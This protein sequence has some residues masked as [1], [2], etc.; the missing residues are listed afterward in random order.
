MAIVN[1]INAPRRD[2][3]GGTAYD[4]QDIFQCGVAAYYDAAAG[5]CKLDTR[6]LPLYNFFCPVAGGVPA[7]CASSVGTFTPVD[8]SSMVSM[9]QVIQRSFAPSYTTIHDTNTPS[10]AQM[11]DYFNKPATLAEHLATTACVNSLYASMPTQGGTKAR[12]LYYPFTFTLY[13]LPFSWFYQCTLSGLV[14]VDAS[15][16]RNVFACPTHASR[17]TPAEYKAYTSQGD[18]FATYVTKVRGGYTAAQVAAYSASSVTRAQADWAQAVREVL[19]ETFSN[20]GADRTYAQCFN[21]QDWIEPTD[22]WA[23]VIIRSYVNPTCSDA[24]LSQGIKQYN[25]LHKTAMSPS[26]VSAFLTE[27][28]G[29][30]TPQVFQ[31]YGVNDTAVAGGHKSLMRLILDFGS[32]RLQSKGEVSALQ[33]NRVNATQTEAVQ[34]DPSMPDVTDPE[35]TLFI[36]QALNSDYLP[37]SG[38]LPGYQEYTD[39]DCPRALSTLTIGSEE[40]RYCPVFST[41][42]T[43]CAY[44]PFAWGVPSQAFALDA[45]SSSLGNLQAYFTGLYSAVR[46]RYALKTA[47]GY[48]GLRASAAELPFFTDEDAAPAT[49]FNRAFV[50]D[51]TRVRSYMME[52]N[53]NPNTPVMCTIGNQTIN[54]TQCTDPNF[55]ALQQ[56]VRQTY[57]KPGPRT[58]PPGSQLDWDTARAMLVA[59]AIYSFASTQRD[60]SRQ[61]L[62]SLFDNAT[63][64]LANN[65]AAQSRVCQFTATGG[66]A[67]ARSVTPWLTGSW[68]PFDKCD[69]TDSGV[70]TSFTE[71]VDVACQYGAPV[72]DPAVGAS[73]TQRY[74]QQMPNADACIRKQGQKTVSN[75]VYYNTGYNLC[76]QTVNEDDVCQHDQ[77]M[78]GGTDGIP[79]QD[80]ATTGNLYSLQNFTDLVWPEGADLGLFGSVLLAGGAADYGFIRVPASHIGGHHLGLII[81]PNANPSLVG[82]MR[83]ARVPLKAPGRRTQLDTWDSRDVREWVAQLNAS[84]AA[85]DAAYQASGLKAGFTRGWECPLRQRAFYTSSVPKFAPSLPSARRSKILFGDL[86]GG[87]YAHPTQSRGSAADQFG[88]YTTTNGFCFCPLSEEI[89]R[90]QCSVPLGVTNQSD[91]SLWSTIQ[92]LRGNLWLSSRTFAPRTAAND[93]KACGVQMDWPFVGGSLRDGSAI[94]ASDAAAQVWAQ[95]SDVEARRCHVLDRM[96]EFRY[97]YASEA[98]LRPSGA[99]TLASGVCHTG[100]VQRVVASSSR[101]VRT[102]KN[103]DNAHLR[104]EAAGAVPTPRPSSKTPAQAT[105]RARLFRQRCSTCSPVP[106][107]KSRGG[108]PIPAES[109]FGVPYRHSAERA[110]AADLREAVCAGQADCG[111]ILNETS[112]APGAFMAAYLTAPHT[113]FLVGDTPGTPSAG[114][115][116]VEPPDDTQLWARPWVYC[117]SKEALRTGANCTG[118]IPKHQWRANKVD[119]CHASITLALDGRQDPMAQTAVCNMDGRLSALCQAIDKARS[120]VASANCIASGD[121]ACA[122]Q[123]F[124]YSPSTWETSN[125]QFVHETVRTYY[126][127]IDRATPD[128]CPSDIDIAQLKARNAATL[129]LC[130]AVPISA[131]AQVLGG[132][133]GLVVTMTRVITI[134][135]SMG[136]HLLSTLGDSGGFGEAK[137]QAILDWQELKRVMGSAAGSVSDLFADLILFQGAVGPWLLRMGVSACNAIN[138]ASAYFKSVWCNLLIWQLPAFLGGL[139]A[140]ATW[141]DVGFQTL[142]DFMDTIFMKYLPQAFMD[143]AQRGYRGAFQ[144]DLFGNKKAAYEKRQA[145]TVAT[146]AQGVPM[147]ASERA[148]YNQRN[149][150][151]TLNNAGVSA[152]AN[153]AA[154]DAAGTAAGDAAKTT[155]TATGE[156]LRALGTIGTAASVVMDLFNIYQGYETAKKIAEAMENYPKFWTVFDFDGIYSTIDDL[157]SFIAQDVTCYASTGAAQLSCSAATLPTL[158]SSQA[159]TMAPTP[160][161]CWAEAQEV[162][163]MPCFVLDYLHFKLTCL[164]DDLLF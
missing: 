147:T 67:K 22:V 153:N 1:G 50:F 84:I 60:I 26:T 39:N 19:S 145:N 102:E 136:F 44:P 41:G 103:A 132:V 10:L 34:Y 113:L 85:D 2:T 17:I 77:G 89:Q 96:D 16:T 56:H 149:T 53:P 81:E 152:A 107:F 59:G 38:T 164:L 63:S 70:D 139:K 29:A 79:V 150:E 97:Q 9:C 83:V 45:S 112:W 21:E 93:D 73:T 54:F 128:I 31:S 104:C 148:A 80:F 40:V 131:F 105:E 71:T 37:A 28:T 114:T 143:M 116:S 144:S 12:G 138:D 115:A 142:N 23:K 47:G 101:C 62:L 69:V 15:S 162:S 121:P 154:K 66:L 87:K 129:Q 75:N 163:P 76:K 98:R 156:T 120:L 6:V 119:T 159:M 94:L 122:V 91:C 68:N 135:I 100:R 36:T 109:S 124:V 46:S 57:L 111:G 161:M 127:A 72:C 61:Y 126:N 42:P 141:C 11:F 3:S 130:P 140:L 55:L 25:E 32:Q 92:S 90:D 99:T 137:A 35:Y 52:I 108:V 106:V 78:A 14:A 95:A 7:A 158:D 155:T 65:F 18:D 30:T 82:S 5:Q 74:Y 4:A 64:C 88:P 24:V 86:T 49:D 51:L 157:V 123:E 118:A 117:G 27:H 125:Q 58:V 13:E 48:P 160:T 151:K 133:R 146:A 33:L 20:H 43:G 8:V 134:V 110:L